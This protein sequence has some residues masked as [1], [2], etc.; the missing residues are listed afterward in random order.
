MNSDCFMKSKLVFSWELII[1]VIQLDCA[2]L[3]LTLRQAL[4]FA[5]S[6]LQKSNKIISLYPTQNVL[7][8]SI[9][10]NKQRRPNFIAF[11]YFYAPFSSILI[12][13]LIFYAI[14]HGR[15]QTH[16]QCALLLNLFF[17]VHA[18]GLSYVYF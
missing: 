13:I 12:V 5:Q 17:F 9:H 10:T 16:L 3:H 2:S 4:V 1:I 8:S 14:L 6:F 7:L 15:K 11:G 18:F